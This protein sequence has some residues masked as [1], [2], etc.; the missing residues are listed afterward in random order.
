M[1]KWIPTDLKKNAL[2]K[3][4]GIDKGKLIPVSRLREA[5]KAKGKLGQRARFALNARKFNH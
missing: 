4:L 2:H 1:N 3:Q 5:A